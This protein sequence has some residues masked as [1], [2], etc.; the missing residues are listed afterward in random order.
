VINQGFSSPR[1]YPVQCPACGA[2]AGYPTLVQTIRAKPGHIRVDISCLA[3]K[4]QWTQEVE[5]ERR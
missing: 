5:I 1:Q 3:C 2:V 4:E